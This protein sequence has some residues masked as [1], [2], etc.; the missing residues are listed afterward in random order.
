MN[1]IYIYKKTK[2][3]GDHYNIVVAVNYADAKSWTH[4]NSLYKLSKTPGYFQLIDASQAVYKK[5]YDLAKSGIKDF[6]HVENQLF[7]SGE[8]FAERSEWPMPFE[9]H[10]IE[11]ATPQEIKAGKR[12]GE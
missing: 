12:G 6:D 10:T 11:H 1:A 9:L 8:V 4:A 2:L 7:A 3:D 5:I